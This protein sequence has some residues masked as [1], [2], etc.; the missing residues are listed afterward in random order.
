MGALVGCDS[1]SLTETGRHSD[2]EKLQEQIDLLTVVPAVTESGSESRDMSHESRGR[3]GGV[4]QSG[5]T[6]QEMTM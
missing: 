5:E 3:G 2:G 4:R 6:K 1:H